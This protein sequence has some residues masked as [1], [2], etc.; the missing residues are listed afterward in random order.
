MH[1]IFVFA[2]LRTES[3]FD[4]HYVVSAILPVIINH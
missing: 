3:D 2:F 1:N 4:S